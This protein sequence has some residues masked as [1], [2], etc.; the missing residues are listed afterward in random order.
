MNLIYETDRLLLKV[1]RPDWA[2]KVLD[3]YLDNKYVFE[4]YEALRP[5]NFYTARYQKSIL[6]CEYSMAMKL[7]TVRFWVFQKENPKDI[8]GTVCF[9]DMKR[10]IYDSCELGYKFDARYWHKGYATEALM[11]GISIMFDDLKLHRIEAFVMP[12]NKPSIKLLQSLSFQEEGLL[13]K[14]AKING[15]WE[16]HILYGLVQT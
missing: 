8:I 2:H 5:P 6:S 15:T 3:F 13:H 9:R 12:N 1:L 14:N 4:K 10:S 7:T 11:E 16:D